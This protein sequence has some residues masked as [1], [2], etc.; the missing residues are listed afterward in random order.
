MTKIMNG[1]SS[2]EAPFVIDPTGLDQWFTM[3]VFHIV[4]SLSMMSLLT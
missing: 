4:S 2:Q 3:V 1:A